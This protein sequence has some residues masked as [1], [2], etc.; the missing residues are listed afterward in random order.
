MDKQNI[1]LPKKD[2]EKKINSEQ[3]YLTA[4]GNYIVQIKNQLH[5]EKNPLE[6]AR[7]QVELFETTNKHVI[8]EQ[9]IKDN[10]YQFNA[11]F[12]PRYEHELAECAKYIQQ[13]VHM[14]KGE[15]DSR[16]METVSEFD[17]NDDIEIQL[18]VYKKLKALMKYDPAS[19]GSNK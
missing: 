10:V 12:L 16:V 14:A 2:F 8:S 9:I 1:I 15:I 6:H 4:L 7:L 18:M 11:V 19:S 5:K 3:Q 17:A 13:L